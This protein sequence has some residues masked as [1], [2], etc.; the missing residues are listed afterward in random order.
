MGYFQIILNTCTPWLTRNLLL[1]NEAIKTNLRKK[2]TEKVEILTGYI[3]KCGN[4]CWLV[5]PSPE[6]KS[7][8]G[9]RWGEDEKGKI[10]RYNFKK[11]KHPSYLCAFIASTNQFIEEIHL[12]TTFPF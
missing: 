10:L 1:W 4:E 12:I 6:T 5:F 8:D 3:G 7:E 11:K 9:V 2:Q